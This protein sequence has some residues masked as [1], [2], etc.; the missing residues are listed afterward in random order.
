MRSPSRRIHAKHSVQMAATFTA[1]CVI[2]PLTTACSSFSGFVADALPHWA[3]GFPAAAPPRPSDPGY[4]DYE[5]A[6][7]ANAESSAKFENPK[8]ENSKVPSR[9]SR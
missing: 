8:L 2:L 4:E 3:G 6:L 7:H 1:L 5:R 9:T